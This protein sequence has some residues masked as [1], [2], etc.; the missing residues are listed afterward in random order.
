MI[1]NSTFEITENYIKQPTFS[2]FDRLYNKKLKILKN[3]RKMQD[4]EVE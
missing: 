2:S 1:F 4:I 3:N